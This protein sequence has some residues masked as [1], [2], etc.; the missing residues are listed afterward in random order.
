MPEFPETV[1]SL[2]VRVRDPSNRAAWDQFEQLY[3]PVIFRTAR[4]KGLQHADALDLVQQ[5]FLAVASAIDKYEKRDDGVRFRHWLSRVTRNA[6]LRALSRGPRDRASGGTG[7]VDV[8][9]EIPDADAET[10]ALLA[11]EYRRELFQRAAEQVRGDVH[12][13]T[14]LAFEMTSLQQTSIERTAEVLGISTGSVYAAR[15]RVMRRIRNAV[16]KLEEAERDE[17]E[18]HEAK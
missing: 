18:I 1:D 3:R 4:A 16:V 12:E 9:A 17:E 5:V 7:M 14:W 8:L 11:L 10:D 15:S 2:I 6:I 13:S